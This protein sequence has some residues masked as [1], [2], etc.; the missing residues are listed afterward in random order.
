MLFPALL[1]GM[2]VAVALAF[3][4]Q[5]LLEWIPFIYVSFLLTIGA[6][7]LLSIM[8]STICSIG[9]CRNRFI[10]FIVGLLLTLSL[11][12]GKFWFQ[13][14]AKLADQQKALAV[15][16]LEDD[17]F[18]FEQN[19]ALAEARAAK[20]MSDWSITDYLQMR[21]D[22]GWQIGRGGGG[23]PVSGLFVYLIWLLEAGI[24]FFIGISGSMAQSAEPYSEKLS[25]WASEEEHIMSLPVTD[26]EMVA[27][28][29]SATSVEQ[30][31]EIPIPKT[32]QS[33]VF[34]IYKTNSIPGQELE[35]AYLTVQLLELS[36]NNKGE[37]VRTETPLV[38]HA[39][40]SSEKRKELVENA[41]LLQEALADYREA[42]NEDALNEE[43]EEN[44]ESQEPA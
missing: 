9:H 29:Q 27:Q 6:G 5:L 8:G 3:V 18:E 28:I 20:I 1:I 11:L 32:D 13:Y 26:A 43:P 31:L 25:T 41:S 39:V 2:A 44:D 4:Y 38:T 22:Q 23:A 21:V 36:V 42:V 15:S 34:A 24:I 10:G 30:L 7:F 40:L 35:D 33:N 17:N 37:E 14:Q 19:Q 16:I 12:G